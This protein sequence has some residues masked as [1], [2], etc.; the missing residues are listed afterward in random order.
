MKRIAALVLASGL[1]FAACSSSTEPAANQPDPDQFDPP[2]GWE[3]ATG[4][5]APVGEG[6]RESP[7]P[8]NTRFEVGPW[9]WT[10]TGF[11]P[12]ANEALEAAT[13][14]TNL[15]YKPPPP[16]KQCVIVTVSAEYTGIDGKGEGDLSGAAGK[17]VVGSNGVPETNMLSDCYVSTEIEDYKDVL[18]GGTLTGDYCFL[19]DTAEIDT[20]QFTLK[21]WDDGMATGIPRVFFALT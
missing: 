1:L 7:I 9:A 17:S 13:L 16:G 5:F 18:A 21:E 20:L 3:D 15:T 6:S 11:T 4:E 10:V 14:N 12:N 19:V 2:P 8:L